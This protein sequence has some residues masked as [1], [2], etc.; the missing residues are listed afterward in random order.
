[1][2]GKVEELVSRNDEIHTDDKAEHQQT[3]DQLQQ[4][5]GVVEGLAG[6]V[7][8]SH[9]KILEAIKEVMELAGQPFEHSK[10]STTDIQDKIIEAKP[11]EQQLLPAPEKYDDSEVQL[12]LDRLVDLKYDDSELQEKLSKLIEDKYDDAMVIEKLDRLVEEAKYDDTAVREK[13]EELVEAKYDDTAVREKLEELVEAKYD[14]TVVNEKLD[15][16]VTHSSTAEQAFTQLETLDKVHQSVVKTAADISEFLSHQ[17]QRISDEH[18]D[19]EK[20]LQDTIVAVARKRAEKEHLEASVLSLKDEE[21]RIRSNITSLRTEQ[22]SLIRQKTRLTGDVSSLETAMRLRKEELAEM[23]GRAEK[24]ER[25]ILEGVMDHSRVLLMSRAT[26]SSNDSMS[27]KRVK[28]PAT[29]DMVAAK[30]S[31]KPVMNMALSAKRNLAP[32]GQTGAARRIASLGQINNNMS[33]GGVKRSQSVRSG[34]GGGKAYRKRSWGGDM[35]FAETDKE[36]LSVRE[37]VEEVDENET[38][39]PMEEGHDAPSEAPGDDESDTGTL[40]RSSR[41]TT[42]M[43]TSTDLY[44][45][46]EAGYSDYGDTGSEWTESVVSSSIAATA[47]DGVE[48]GEVVVYGQ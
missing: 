30:P 44:T 13:L 16:L 22:E 36:N 39:V 25:R 27:R 26:K 19:R 10:A 1:V 31:P 47:G 9:P 21:D 2:F 46:S 23:E 12:K 24:L 43:T 7:N 3:R 35:G 17:T 28:R 20:T 15:K 33:S 37:T 48:G 32:P 29:D 11:P 14:D 40:R 41:G 34:A 42:I 38:P 45:E 18:E 8:E 4:A 5:L 6:E